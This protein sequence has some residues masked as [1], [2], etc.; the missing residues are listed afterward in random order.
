MVRIKK[1]ELNKGLDLKYGEELT[2]KEMILKRLLIEANEMLRSIYSILNREGE[3]TNWSGARKRVAECL[4]KQHAIIYPK[5]VCVADLIAFV[6]SKSGFI[7]KKIKKGK[8]DRNT[9][10]R[11]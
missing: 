2:K 7:D 8:N 9:K 6:K 1:N 11:C 4:N 3:N 5:D 10:C